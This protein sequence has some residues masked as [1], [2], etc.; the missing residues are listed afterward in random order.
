MIGTGANQITPIY[1]PIR[2]PDIL[3]SL[4]VRLRCQVT[5]RENSSYIR[6]GQDLGMFVDDEDA[7]FTCTKEYRNAKLLNPQN[8][9]KSRFTNSA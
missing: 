1:H 8:Q 3:L 4:R 7:K 5:Q 6:L 2:A 9:I